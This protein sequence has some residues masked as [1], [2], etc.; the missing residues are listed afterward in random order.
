MGKANSTSEH[1]LMCFTADPRAIHQLVDNTPATSPASWTIFSLRFIFLNRLQ[2]SFHIKNGICK[3]FCPPSEQS[4][5]RSC[6]PAFGSPSSSQSFDFWH[7][8]LQIAD[9]D[10]FSPG[11]SPPRPLRC[12]SSSLRSEAYTILILYK[13]FEHAKQQPR[14]LG[15]T[16]NELGIRKWLEDQ[17][18]E[19]VTTSDK[20]GEGS[21][22]DKHLVDAEVI[23]TTP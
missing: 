8:F 10:C 23:I 19:L 17:G 7:K 16:E 4:P 12:K 22:F 3:I 15:T 21:E 9:C 13:G 5:I 14:L 20:E 11:Q 18:H 6:F 1:V 2:L